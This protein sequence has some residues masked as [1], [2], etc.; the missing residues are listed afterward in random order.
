MVD[1]VACLEGSLR[2]TLICHPGPPLHTRA[3]AGMMTYDCNISSRE[4]LHLKKKNVANNHRMTFRSE[5][6]RVF[7][8]SFLRCWWDIGAGKVQAAFRLVARNFTIKKKG[9]LSMCERLIPSPSRK[10]VEA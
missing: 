1:S 10:M 9:H 6:V 8:E 3:R 4:G 5:G 7:L 2:S